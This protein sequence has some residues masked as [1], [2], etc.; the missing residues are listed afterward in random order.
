MTRE[1]VN[2]KRV[3]PLRS[4]M[5][6]AV[7]AGGL[8]FVSGTLPFKGDREIE[9]GVFATQMHQVMQNLKAILEDA[10]SS[11]DKA[12]KM[13]VALR[14]MSDFPAMNEIYRSYFKAGNYPARMTVESPLALEEFLVE[15]DCVAEA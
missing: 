5:S 13:T 10:G 12:V 14:H 11:L 6:H 7:K 9:K 15:I 1:V 8:V 4:P 3:T 2:S